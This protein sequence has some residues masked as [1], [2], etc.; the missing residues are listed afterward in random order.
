LGVQSAMW[1]RW[2]VY[3]GIR[4][5]AGRRRPGHRLRSTLRNGG[6]TVVPTPRSN[7]PSLSARRFPHA[8][9][10]SGPHQ[11]WSALDHPRHRVENRSSSL[12]NSSRFVHCALFNN[13]QP[14]PVARSHFSGQAS[15]KL[16]RLPPGMAFARRPWKSAARQDAQGRWRTRHPSRQ[17]PTRRN[18]R[19]R[20]PIGPSPDCRRRRP[21][22][23]VL[24]HEP[25]ERAWSLLPSSSYGTS[26]AEGAEA[27]PGSA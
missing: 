11:E 22:S 14:R 21:R 6:P 25:G 26:A 13:T 20:S 9:P 23:P 15:A 4:R 12:R 5:G 17:A 8:L 3:E 7:F 24:L 1:R 16:V 27:C 10:L 2:D 18:S 19:R